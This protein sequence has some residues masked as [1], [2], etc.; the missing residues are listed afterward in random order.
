MVMSNTI[1]IQSLPQN[2]T[3]RSF[4]NAAGLDPESN[5]EWEFS[6]EEAIAYQGKKAKA[7]DREQTIQT[8]GREMFEMATLL[9]S[10]SIDVYEDG[11]KI[12]KHGT[13]V[14]ALTW[15]F[16]RQNPEIALRE[17]KAKVR[18]EMILKRSHLLGLSPKRGRNNFQGYF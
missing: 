14:E 18:M 11:K 3:T 15:N 7:G 17:L 6:L 2:D 4:W 16:Y 13:E 5:Y 8:R 9:A 10:P 1:N 12:N